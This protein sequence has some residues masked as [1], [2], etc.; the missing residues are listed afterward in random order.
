M[1][2]GRSTLILFGVFVVL[3][4]AIYFFEIKGGEKRE[5]KSKL[6]NQLFQTD[7]DSVK[8][9]ILSGNYGD[10]ICEKNG[11]DWIITAPVLTQGDAQSIESNLDLILST[12]IERKIADSTDD[13]SLYGLLEPRGKVEV[14]TQNGKHTVVLIGDENP[15]GDLIFIKN[16]EDNAVYTTNK[17]LW[18]YANKKLY[19]L[20]DKKIMHFNIDEVHKISVNSRTK[21]KVSLEKIAGKWRIVA[22]VNLPANDSEVK[23]LL[24]RLST[25]RVKDFIDENPSDLKKYGLANPAV[26]ITLELGESLARTSFV[27]GDSAKNDGG[28]F[29]AK[30]ETRRPVFT[31]EK[32]TVNGIT[33]S[34]FDLQ[35]KTILGFDSQ[36]CERIAWQIAKQEYTATKVDSVNWMVVAPETLQVDENSMRRWLEAL[37]DFSVDELESYQPKSLSVYGF[38]K[39]TLRLAFYDKDSKLGELLVGKEISEKYYVKINNYPHVYRIKKNTFEQIN[40]KP[41]DLTVKTVSTDN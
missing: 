20:R 40:K 10:I 27:V 16:S 38:D 37:R 29:Y 34:A 39:P 33:K 31:I 23:S 17:S 5:K 19:D 11:A 41:E 1:K 4:A 3:F 25:G 36:K 30:E 21:G 2:K 32:W 18:T 26:M 14:L 35:D 24:T 6:A 15:T 28:G 13:L 12:T 22:P 7:K 8:Q 9:L